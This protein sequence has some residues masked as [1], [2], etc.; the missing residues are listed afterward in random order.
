MRLRPACLL[1]LA[2]ALR[3]DQATTEV[4][5]LGRI[6]LR[7]VE[8]QREMQ[9]MV[10]SATL[11]SLVVRTVYQMPPRDTEMRLA[12]MLIE[13]VRTDS[14]AAKAG[15]RSG[16]QIIAIEGI[17]IRG[18]TETQFDEVMAMEVYDHLTLTVRRRNGFRSFKIVIPIGAPTPI[19]STGSKR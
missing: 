8:M 15:V 18:L 16:M 7:P 9:K 4:E 19:T 6:V 14:R 5:P 17:D 2:A 13:E 1:F 12:M 10:V 11:A 3:A